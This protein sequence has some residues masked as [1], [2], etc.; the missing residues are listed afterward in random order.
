MKYHFVLKG[1]AISIDQVITHEQAADILHSFVLSVP[2]E[3]EEVTEEDL[4]ASIDAIVADDKPTKKYKKH[5]ADRKPA[6]CGNCG[7][8]GH[9]KTT[10]PK[11]NEPTDPKEEAGD[12]LSEEDYRAVLECKSDG[13]TSRETADQLELNRREVNVAFGTKI[14]ESYLQTR[15]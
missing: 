9:R 2:D 5:K 12:A 13:L 8:T 14:Y 4:D 15:K 10:C 3:E 6:T 1:G 7:E 11:D